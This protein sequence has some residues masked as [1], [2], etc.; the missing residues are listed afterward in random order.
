MQKHKHSRTCRK[1]GKAEC[2]FGIPFP[3]MRKTVIL[4]PFDGDDRSMYEEH[5]KKVQEHLVSDDISITF[6]DFLCNIKLSETDY[7]KAVQTSITSAKVFLKR[8]PNE[9]RINPY[10]KD[11]LDVWKGNHDI[12]YI[13]DAY[14]C[15]MYIVSY[16]NKSSKGMSTLM[17]EACKEAK[18]GTQTLIQSVR[19]IGNK[20]LNAVEVSAQEAA[21]LILQ[22]SMSMKSRGCEFIPT[23]PIGERTYELMKS[24]K[25][26]NRMW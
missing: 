9:S 23:A 17:A 5:Y 3:P 14:A 25:H 11:M 18:K 10:I 20:F 16:I 13:L 6:D 2:R 21:Y 8:E 4:Q 26:V 22:Q 15:A 12:Q 7:R 19:H 24:K 1:G